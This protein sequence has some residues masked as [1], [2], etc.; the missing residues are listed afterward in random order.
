MLN[1]CYSQI[2]Y[3]DARGVKIGAKRRSSSHVNLWFRRFANTSSLQRMPPMKR[4]VSSYTQ[5]PRTKPY[6]Q[7]PKAPK[8]TGQSS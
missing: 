5:S 3:L 1:V 8:W 2:F 6:T 4:P 7:S